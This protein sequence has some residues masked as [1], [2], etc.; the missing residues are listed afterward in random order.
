MAPV[1]VEKDF[2][3]T[4]PCVSCGA[5]LSFA[6]GTTALRCDYCGAQ[7]AIPAGE[8]GVEELDLEAWLKSLQGVAE[9]VEEERVRCEKCGAEE[10]LDGVHFATKCSFCGTALVSKSYAGRH[11]KPR[12][13][14]PFQVD[15]RAAH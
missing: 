6:P 8:A 3:R 13:L 1:A 12:S 10:M 5:K 11:V 9:Y 7:N 4:F 15:A 14:V 2:I